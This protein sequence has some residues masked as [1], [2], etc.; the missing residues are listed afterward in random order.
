MRPLAAIPQTKWRKFRKTKGTFAN[1]GV[2]WSGTMELSLFVT[3][4]AAG[5]TWTLAA[6]AYQPINTGYF[7]STF[8]VVLGLLVGALL[9]GWNSEAQ[10]LRISLFGGAVASYVAFVTWYLEN[11]TPARRFTIGYAIAFIGI[12]LLALIEMPGHHSVSYFVNSFAS[13]LLIGTSMAAM[14]LGHYYL[15]APWMSLEP[16]K[17]LLIATAAAA[18]VRGGSALLWLAWAEETGHLADA[19]AVPVASSA[20]WGVYFFLRWVAGIIAPIVL[21]IMSW[22]ALRWKNTQAATGMLYVV[23]IATLLGEATAVALKSHL[24]VSW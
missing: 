23:V 16:L 1:Y 7:R 2:G 19:S 18:V 14:L 24:G 10:L 15:T 6:L 11:P 4:M 9:A 22:Q 17:G 13:A 21:V 3:L 12:V 8:L 5:L 20:E